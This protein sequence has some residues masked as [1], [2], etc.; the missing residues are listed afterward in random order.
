MAFWRRFHEINEDLASVLG[1]SLNLILLIIIKT[2]KVRSLQNYN[3]L[4]IQCC[5]VDMFLIVT[6]FIVKPVIVFHKRNEYLLSNGLLRS[7]GGSIE[8]VGICLWSTAI[9]FC[10][11]SMPVSYIFRYRT[12][13]LN[14]QISKK[15]YVLS[16]L[17]AMF[18]AFLFGI[19]I[20]KFHYI[21]GR[22]MT[23]LAEEGFPWLMADNEGKVKAASACPGVS[24]L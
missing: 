10:I 5:C 2:I 14:A 17:I 21:D 15:F 19:I 13:C 3:I 12:V 6:S 16:L 20:W 24:V 18:T 4:L 9:F 7:F 8:M 11:S 23:Y 22:A 1:F